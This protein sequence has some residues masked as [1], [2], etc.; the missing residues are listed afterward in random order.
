MFCTAHKPLKSQLD[1]LDAR[2]IDFV[3]DMDIGPRLAQCPS[4]IVQIEDLADELIEVVSHYDAVVLPIGSPAFNF[5]LAQKMSS[6]AVKILFSHSVT[7][8]VED[9]NGV[10]RSVFVHRGFIHANA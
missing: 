9:E 2:S 6:L 5:C 8:C 3:M 10:K 7:D 4:D 1:D